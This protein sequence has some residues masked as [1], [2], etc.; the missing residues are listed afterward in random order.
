MSFPH[1]AVIEREG[2]LLVP[3]S[4]D[5]P[6]PAVRA[7]CAAPGESDFLRCE[8]CGRMFTRDEIAWVWFRRVCAG[9]C[10]GDL[11]DYAG[12]FG[13]PVSDVASRWFARQQA[14]R[15]EVAS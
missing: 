8:G 4:E 7:D 15:A 5:G 1:E 2:Y 12:S 11:M 6:T 14:L 10:L 13:L 3:V 9:R